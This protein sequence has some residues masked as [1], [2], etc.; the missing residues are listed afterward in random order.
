MPDRN[1]EALEGLGCMVL[2]RVGLETYPIAL[3]VCVCV[4]IFCFEPHGCC[5]PALPGSVTKTGSVF[6]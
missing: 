3:A 2:L 1:A 4:N 6:E 5:V